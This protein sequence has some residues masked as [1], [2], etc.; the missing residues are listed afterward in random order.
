MTSVCCISRISSEL[1]NPCARIGSEPML[2]GVSNIL[3]RPRSCCCNE[4]ES[5]DA[6][7]TIKTISSE[8]FH[9]DTENT[10]HTRGCI[11]LT[12]DSSCAMRA[13]A[14]DV[15]HRSPYPHFDSRSSNEDVPIH[16]S[17][18][19]SLARPCLSSHMFPLRLYVGCT[20]QSQVPSRPIR[21]FICKCLRSPIH[22][23]A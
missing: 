19:C 16:L 22:E 17:L 9:D 20:L 11:R 12:N 8:M 15:I 2:T 1:S 13:P 18:P 3:G 10:T 5:R 14:A 7:R 21:E 23:H 4:V 6:T